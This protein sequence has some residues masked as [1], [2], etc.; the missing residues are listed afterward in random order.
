MPPSATSRDKPRPDT[1]RPKLTAAQLS[2]TSVVTVI[3]SAWST[4][5]PFQTTLDTDIPA[6]GSLEGEEQ[7]VPRADSP[8]LSPI[9]LQSLSITGVQSGPEQLSP[10]PAEDGAASEP[11]LRTRLANLLAL[12]CA[13]EVDTFTLTND[14]AWKVYIRTTELVQK[15]REAA[16]Y[17]MQL[18]GNSGEYLEDLDSRVWQFLDTLAKTAMRTLEALSQHR[19][20]MR[21]ELKRQLQLFLTVMRQESEARTLHLHSVVTGERGDSCDSHDPLNDAVVREMLSQEA[22]EIDLQPS[23]GRKA[24]VVKVREPRS[25]AFEGERGLEEMLTLEARRVDVKEGPDRR[26]VLVERRKSTAV[27]TVRRESGGDVGMSSGKAN[28]RAVLERMEGEVGVRR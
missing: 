13:T 10:E 17:E 12:A 4:A 24:F 19:W 16:G 22:G 21:R 5:K 11:D 15:W 18:A 26:A 25:K 6:R 27:G 23:P 8:T 20:G 14:F 1:P 3:P 9:L 2:Q 28:K 7:E